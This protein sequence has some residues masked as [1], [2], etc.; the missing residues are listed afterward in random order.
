MWCKLFNCPDSSKWKNIL[1]LIELL[2]C[3]PMAN[4]RIERAFSVMKAIK[5]DHRNCFGEDHFDD[6]MHI[7][8]D[9]P[10]LSQWNA[11]QAVP[12]W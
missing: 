11:S 4:D 1:A 7:T 9:G 2:F 8:I 6:L 10:P 5:T 3:L 12:L